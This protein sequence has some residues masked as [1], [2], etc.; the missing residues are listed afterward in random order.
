V[1]II[2]YIPKS[3]CLLMSGSGETHIVQSATPMTARCMHACEWKVQANV[4]LDA[5]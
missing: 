5:V 2:F 1:R 3:L 4:L